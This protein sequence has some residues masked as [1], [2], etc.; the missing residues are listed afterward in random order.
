MKA[1]IT[2]DGVYAPG[3]L[4]SHA[5]IPA[6]GRTVYLSG[7]LARDPTSGGV[8]HIG[9]IDGQ[10]RLCF[11]NIERILKAAGGG[12]DNIAKMTVF[13]R[14]VA[15]YAQFN[16]VRRSVMG[17]IAY[18]SSTVI[19]ALVETEALVEVEVIA[20]LPETAEASS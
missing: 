3:G 18:A 5:I 15:D 16:A 2:A 8:A 10:A 9:S 6:A 20:V 4:F 14:D 11:A 17:Q 1:K 12:L 13:L 19:A 7:C